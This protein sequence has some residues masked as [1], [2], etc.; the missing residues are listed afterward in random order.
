MTK[1]EEKAQAQEQRQIKRRLVQVRGVA[2]TSVGQIID[3]TNTLALACGRIGEKIEDVPTQEQVLQ[4]CG[5]FMSRSGQV[6]TALVQAL[7]QTMEIA[8][9]EAMLLPAETEEDV[10]VEGAK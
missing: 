4:L 10:E 9:L 1:E 8:K 2:S 5:T 7:A 3:G 6:G